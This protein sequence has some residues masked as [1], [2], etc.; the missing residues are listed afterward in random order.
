MPKQKH[1]GSLEERTRADDPRRALQACGGLRL[2][3]RGTDSR[4]T[5]FIYHVIPLEGVDPEWHLTEVQHQ[6]S[7]T[8]ASGGATT[9]E[10]AVGPRNGLTA[11]LQAQA[12]VIHAMHE[13]EQLCQDPQTEFALHRQVHGHPF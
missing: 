3:R 7:V 13:Q 6:S 9:L 10:E 11:Q 5:E 12:D 8:I 2:E 4:Q 1:F